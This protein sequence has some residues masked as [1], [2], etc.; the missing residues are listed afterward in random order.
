MSKTIDEQISALMDGELTDSNQVLEQL[1]KDP[2][3]KQRWQRYHIISDAMRSSLPRSL[4]PDFHQTLHERLKSEPTILAPKRLSEFVA[5]V[6]RK[7]S[8]IAIAAS[9]AV[10][11]VLSV[12]MFT[13]ETDTAPNMAQMPDRSEFVR[14]TPQS[15]PANTGTL[16]LNPIPANTATYHP[17]LNKY[18]VD[19]NQSITRSHIQGVMPYARIVV[20][21]S[22]NQAK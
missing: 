1:N 22:D 11:T 13:T 2:E 4:N 20:S 12:Q 5:P 14:L 8:G 7:V 9:V 3:F 6:M 15:S 16:P 17:Q 10:A 18:L 21:P 19:H